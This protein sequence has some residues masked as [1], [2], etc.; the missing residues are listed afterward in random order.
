MAR[1]GMF[2]HRAKCCTHVPTLPNFLVGEIL[3]E[4][5][6]AGGDQTIDEWIDS[7]RAGPL[8]I[9][10]PPVVSELYLQNPPDVS[11]QLGCPLLDLDGLCTIY[12][13]RPPLCISYHCLYPQ[14]PYMIGFWNSLASLLQLHCVIT[15]QYLIKML[16]F[17]IS[18]CNAFWQNHNYTEIWDGEGISSQF[19]GE[20]WQERK[21]YRAFYRECY[22]YLLTHRDT[23][24]QQLDQYRRE[25]LLD[26]LDQSG[27]LSEKRAEQ[28]RN[29]QST[30]IQTEPS[31]DTFQA[32]MGGHLVYFPQH[33]WTIPEHESYI[34]WFHQ[35]AYGEAL[36]F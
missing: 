20:L 13:H 16:G 30:P 31:T 33:R 12:E 3:T 2:H 5:Y 18:R 9:H 34:L 1:T 25:Q 24:R 23:I 7:G 36:S 35:Q 28:I 8:Y 29:Q 32:F 4:S 17:N 11:Q 15:A 21:D 19:V 27:E 26:S 14:N 22:A 10:V 6:A